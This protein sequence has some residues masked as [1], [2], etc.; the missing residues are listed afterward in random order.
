MED[1]ESENTF[2]SV[3]DYEF[4]KRMYKIRISKLERKTRALSDEANLLQAQNDYFVKI[5][6]E[7][8]NL[9]E[10]LNKVIESMEGLLLATV[11][12]YTNE[13][14]NPKREK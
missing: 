6:N 3:D 7:K 5:I 9:I 1:F 2:L 14:N 4:K 11:E 10:Q 12:E 13:P 8:N